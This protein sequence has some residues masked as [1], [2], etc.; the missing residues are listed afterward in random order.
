MWTYSQLT[1]ELRSSGI[2][3]G[4]CYSGHG[5]GKNN[6]SLQNVPDVGPIPCGWYSAGAPFDSQKTGPYVMRL[7]PDPDTDTF[8]RSNF[9]FHGDSIEHPGQA[10]NG[11]IAGPRPVRSRFWQSAD[12]RI[13][14]V[15]GLTAPQ[16]P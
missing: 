16:I 9:E 4:T 15:S 11:C 2:L 7:T 10:S 8:G 5:E 3:I 13:L 14:V 12:H 1:G 6:P